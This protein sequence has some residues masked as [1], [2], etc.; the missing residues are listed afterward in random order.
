MDLDAYFECPL[1]NGY[2]LIVGGGA[3]TRKNEFDLDCTNCLET[4]TVSHD[5]LTQKT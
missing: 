4:T 1:C 5:E 2:A 3:G